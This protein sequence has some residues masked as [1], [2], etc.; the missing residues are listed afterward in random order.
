MTA[1]CWWEELALAADTEAALLWR[2]GFLEGTPA[3]SQRRHG[4]GAVSYVATYLTGEI[5][6]HL[7]PKFCDCS[8][9]ESINPQAADGLEVVV[10]DK[11]ELRLT[12]YLNPAPHTLA[13]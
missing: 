9:L 10:R 1:A 8:D 13:V 12:F 3:V 2:N 7:L 11:D 4:R 6:F 5:L